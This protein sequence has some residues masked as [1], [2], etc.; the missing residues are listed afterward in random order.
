MTS[1]Y[2]CVLVIG[3]QERALENLTHDRKPSLL[4]PFL[5]L[6]TCVEA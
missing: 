1:Y 2:H 5:P 6:A 4:G 3:Q